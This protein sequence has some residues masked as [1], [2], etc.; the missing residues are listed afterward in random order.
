MNSYFIFNY[1]IVEFVTKL[2]TQRIGVIL[3]IIILIINTNN[4]NTEDKCTWFLDLK[5]KMLDTK[6]D[7]IYVYTQ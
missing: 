5:L 1:L 6:R 4:Y 3:L 7:L 2:E